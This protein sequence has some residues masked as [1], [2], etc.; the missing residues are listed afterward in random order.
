MNPEI[1]LSFRKKDVSYTPGGCV[2]GTVNISKCN[3]PQKTHVTLRLL[4]NDSL[5]IPLQ[6]S[7][8]QSLPIALYKQNQLLQGQSEQQLQGSSQIEICKLSLWDQPLESD[9]SLPF[10]LFL[11]S[12]LEPTAAETNFAAISYTLSC[13]LEEAENKQ[14]LQDPK[15]FEQ[16]IRIVEF[17]SM[18]A[19]DQTLPFS[20]THYPAACCSGMFSFCF[21]CGQ[22]T[23]C[24]ST[25][26]FL[27]INCTLASSFFL[28]GEIFKMFVECNNQLDDKLESASVAVVREVKMHIDAV[29]FRLEQTLHQ[30]SLSADEKAEDFLTEFQLPLDAFPCIEPTAGE[31]TVLN[32]VR[33]W[34]SVQV[35][36]KG[37]ESIV[38]SPRF[39]FEVRT[40][41]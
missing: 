24:C 34:F 5:S 21:C 29:P 2:E 28:P 10:E 13:T 9:L 12:Y 40:E 6:S 35:K 37:L 16:T 17:P 25:P 32:C 8:P 27:A 20:H 31:S 36:T 15:I 22:G 26:K 38:Q 14:S 18:K 7:P 19:K 39:Y 11:P 3:F 33:Y 1:Q 30:F 41:A 23:C 4:R